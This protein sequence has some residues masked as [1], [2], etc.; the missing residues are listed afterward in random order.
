MDRTSSSVAT[1]APAVLASETAPHAFSARVKPASFSK[2]LF[3]HPLGGLRAVF[4]IPAVPEA[5]AGFGHT[6][7]L[8][9]KCL[10]PHL[11]RHLPALVWVVPA[12]IGRTRLASSA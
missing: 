4:S 3:G 7:A 11:A 6:T 8:R 12:Q 9:A 10:R 2:R 1:S 5:R